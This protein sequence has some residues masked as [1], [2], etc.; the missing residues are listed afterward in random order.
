MLTFKVV[1]LVLLVTGQRVQTLSLLSLNNMYVELEGKRITFTVTE[2][3][4]QSRPGYRNPRIVLN[5]YT[6]SDLC[7]VT[8]LLAYIQRTASLRSSLS[9]FVS[10]RKP[11]LSVSKATLARWLKCVM[12][13]AGIDVDIFK[14]HSIRSASTSAALRGGG[15]Q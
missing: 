8:Y 7:V 3:M 10:F 9:L 1:V 6:D 15:H 11:Y 4:K 13:T 14:P 12:K 2:L 5:S